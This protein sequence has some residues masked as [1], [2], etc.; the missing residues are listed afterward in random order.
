M[1]EHVEKFFHDDEYD[2]DDDVEHFC[3]R[4]LF[5]HLLEVYNKK[6]TKAYFSFY[7]LL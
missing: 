4:S 7:L 5:A 6:I 1:N 3:W 2:D